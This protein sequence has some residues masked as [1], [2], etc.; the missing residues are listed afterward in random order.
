LPTSQPLLSLAITLPL[1]YS[2]LEEKQN[3]FSWN[4]RVEIEGY[5]KFKWFQCLE[6]AREQQ[7]FYVV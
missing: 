1:S 2:S 5:R 6:M 7:A 4:C 3:G